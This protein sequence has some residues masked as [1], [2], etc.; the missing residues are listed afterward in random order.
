VQAK[1][2]AQRLDVRLTVTYV[3]EP[4]AEWIAL[5]RRLLLRTQSSAQPAPKPGTK[6]ARQVDQ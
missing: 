6:G 3:D 1:R 5:W 4:S 2:P